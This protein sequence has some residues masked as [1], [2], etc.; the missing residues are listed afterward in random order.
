MRQLLKF[1]AGG[2]GD[3]IFVVGIKI[4]PAQLRRVHADLRRREFD[5]SFGNRGRDRVTDRAVLAHHVLVLKDDAGAGAVVGARIGAANQTHDLIGLDAAGARVD[6][7][8]AD[9][10][11]VVDLESRDRAVVFHADL[12][13]DAVIAGVNVG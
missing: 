12:R 10:G 6:R 1:Q 8:R 9:A 11:K 2:A 3:R 7:V 5:K 13:L 4:A